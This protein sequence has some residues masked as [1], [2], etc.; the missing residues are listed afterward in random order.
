MVEQSTVGVELDIHNHMDSVRAVISVFWAPNHH[1]SNSV[2]HPIR[3][4]AGRVE[5]RDGANVNRPPPGSFQQTAWIRSKDAVPVAGDAV[6]GLLSEKFG[7]V[8][9]PYAQLLE[10]MLCRFWSL[11][12]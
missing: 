8:S 5:L 12:M 2:A 7:E 9:D 6:S 10:Q 4:D 3:G 11:M 1:R